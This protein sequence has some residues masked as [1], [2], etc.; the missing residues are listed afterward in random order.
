M[1]SDEAKIGPWLQRKNTVLWA[2]YF[3]ISTTEGRDD[4]QAWFAR[5]L[6]DFIAFADGADDTDLPAEGVRAA[7]PGVGVSGD[8]LTLPGVHDARE[9]SKSEGR[10]GP[11]RP[12]HLSKE[13][14]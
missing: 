11:A 14:G 1:S 3:N 2:G 6:A 13:A 7:G 8:Q 10:P 5:E 9:G 4:A 12:L